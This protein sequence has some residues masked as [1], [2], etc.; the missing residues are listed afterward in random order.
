MEPS[1]NR[2][3]DTTSRPCPSPDERTPMRIY[4]N[5]EQDPAYN[6]A[7]EETM[8]RR[9]HGP[10]LMLWRNGPSVIIGRNQNAM[11]EVDCEAVR[12]LGIPVVRRM[13]GG[14]AVY[15]DTG[16]LNYSCF[17]DHNG[18]SFARFDIFAEPVISALRSFGIQSEFT[19][20]N[21][22]LVDGKK[23]S[24]TAKMFAGDRVLFHGTL[25]FRTD[26]STLTRVLTPDPDKVS[27]KGI[28]SVSA[29]VG[30]L[31]DLLPGLSPS[32]F[33]ERMLRALLELHGMSSPDPLPEDCM[34]EARALADSKY[35]TWAWNFG[36]SPAY[37]YRKKARF[38]GGSV[39]LELAVSRGRIDSARITGDFF[40]QRPAS[41]LEALLKSVEFR[42]DAVRRALTGV[43]I[44]DFMLGVSMED[45][46]SLFV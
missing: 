15:H 39:T 30:N 12:A 42:P 18:D 23:V 8:L 34:R 10:A 25:L 46:L 7:L 31:G 6:L 33:T 13:T 38:P 32:E 20:R 19:G 17:A 9:L 27:F 1:E 4:W 40:G 26:I 24:G 2:P 43:R 21:D 16:N 45:F 37:D 3:V 5:P 14:G 44:D 29:R 36:S 35:R 11:A 22:I 28:R 41:E